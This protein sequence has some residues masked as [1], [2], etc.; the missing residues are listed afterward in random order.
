ME[1]KWTQAE[2]STPGLS[3]RLADE[4]RVLIS[5]DSSPVLIGKVARD[6]A[7]A[8]LL[9]PRAAT[10]LD[11][12]PPWTASECRDL[13]HDTERWFHSIRSRL[14]ASDRNPLH[15]GEWVLTS[16]PYPW[17]PAAFHEHAATWLREEVVEPVASTD[18]AFTAV[19]D[20]FSQFPGSASAL[21]PLRPLSGRDSPRVKAHRRRVREGSLAPVV[22]LRVSGL[23]GH[24]ILD[25]HDR[26]V[27]AIAEQQV[28]VFACLSRTDSAEFNK[29]SGRAVSDYEATMAAIAEAELH[30]GGRVL[31]SAQQQAEASRHLAR[32]LDGTHSSPTRTWPLSIDEWEVS[33]RKT[34]QA[35]LSNLEN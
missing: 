6:W 30:S 7:E 31:G 17:Q 22:L 11:I 14:Q 19:I 23:G 33:A 29:I 5:I 32:Q 16:H 15:P 25:G 28:P 8:H 3:V 2:P 21:I 9:Y 26:L 12:L 18:G 34:S 24:V 1:L 20:F 35:W 4:G 10:N 27:A 13:G